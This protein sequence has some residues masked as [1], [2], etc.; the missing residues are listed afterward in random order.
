MSF[1]Q[2]DGEWMVITDRRWLCHDE[3]NVVDGCSWLVMIYQRLLH[4]SLMMTN[5]DYLIDAY[6]SAQ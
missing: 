5:N 6:S 2:T 4:R 3:Y 1:W